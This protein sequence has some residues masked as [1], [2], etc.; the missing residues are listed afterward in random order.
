MPH[1][2]QMTFLSSGSPG[3]PT[4][5]GVGQGSG[6]FS[7]YDVVRLAGVARLGEGLVRSRGAKRHEH[8][9]GL[10]DGR[11]GTRAA[12]RC[13]SNSSSLLMTIRR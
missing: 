10:L 9:F 12:V 11:P 4:C 8:A 3:R 5:G 2:C 7:Q 1:S 6:Q 13:C